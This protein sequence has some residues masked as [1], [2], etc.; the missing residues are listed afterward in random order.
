MAKLERVFYTVRVTPEELWKKVGALLW[1]RRERSLG[2]PDWSDV[3]HHGGPSYQTISNHEQGWIKSTSKLAQ[4]C[5]ALGLE[6]V[7]VLRA[8]LDS[9]REHASPEA[10]QIVRKYEQ[11]TVQGRAALFAIAQALPD[12][13]PSEPNQ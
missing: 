2:W 13:E 6:L 1:D 12:A 5:E 3:E 11:T 4:H 9:T 7:D 8:A 10:L